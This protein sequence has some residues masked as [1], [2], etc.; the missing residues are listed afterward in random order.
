MTDV[1]AAGPTGGQRNNTACRLGAIGAMLK[2]GDIALAIGVLTI[3]VV[4]ILP[5]P[6]LLLDLALAISIILSVLILMTALFIHTPLEFSAFPTV[7]LISTMLR[8]ALNLASTRLILAH[9]HEGTHAAGHVIEAFGNFVM[10]RQFRHRHHRLHHPGHRE[11]RRHHQGLRPHRRSR[12]ALQPR[13]HAR[14]ADGDRRRPFRRPDRRERGARRRKELEDESGFFGAMDGASKFVRGDA[15]AGLLIVFIN[16]IGGMI[17]GIAQQGMPFADA[18]RTYTLLTVGDGLVTQIPALIVS[19]A[20]GLLVSKAGVAGSADKALLAQLSGYPKAL[21]MSG[22]VMIVM[23]LLPGIPMLP[24]LALGG[25]AGALAYVMDKKQK[26]ALRHQ[27]AGRPKRKTARRRRSR[28][29]PRSRST[30]SRSSSATRCCRWS[31][32]RT[33]ATASPSRSRRCAARSRSR[34]AS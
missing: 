10:A 19:T 26:A 4:L 22:A 7:L 14:Q 9:G 13:R 29:A 28:S 17:I 5:L 2:R 1:T 27:G 34:W 31:I 20:A 33:A 8:L 18:A 3:L 30:T 6:P 12:G 15:I 32:R 24:F 16:I 21:G 23:A 11:L 25:G